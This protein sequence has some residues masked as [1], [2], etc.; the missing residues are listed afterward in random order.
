M[1]R[2]LDCMADVLMMFNRPLFPSRTQNALQRKKR[3]YLLTYLLNSK[4]D[5]TLSLLCMIRR[6]FNDAV[7]TADVV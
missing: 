7:L 6:L 1:G 5:Y 4:R 3:T 2:D